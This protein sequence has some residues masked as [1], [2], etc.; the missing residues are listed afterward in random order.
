M[1]PGSESLRVTQLPEIQKPKIEG[2]FSI[3]HNSESWQLRDSSSEQKTNPKQRSE[4]S[5]QARDYPEANTSRF[6]N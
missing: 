3:L 1:G 6:T 4:E 5:P 2:H